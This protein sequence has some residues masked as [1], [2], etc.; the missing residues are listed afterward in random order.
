MTANESEELMQVQG[1][2]DRARTEYGLLRAALAEALKGHPGGVLPHLIAHTEE[3]G[4]DHTLAALTSTPDRFGLAS[5]EGLPLAQLRVVLPKIADLNWE[6]G[7]LTAD[8]ENLLG[9]LTIADGRVFNVDGRE[10]TIDLATH[11]LRFLDQS[12]EPLEIEAVEPTGDPSPVRT[13]R[14]RRERDR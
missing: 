9:R 3:M 7:R 5:A 1:Y 2:L 6:M 8:R 11:T 14:R 12:T 10:A 4:V 13:R